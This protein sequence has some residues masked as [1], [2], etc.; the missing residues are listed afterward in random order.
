MSRNIKFLYLIKLI[1]IPLLFKNNKQPMIKAIF[2]FMAQLT[3]FIVICVPLALIL[4][5][6]ANIFFELKRITKWIK[7]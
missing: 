6:T 2:I 7:N 4:L 3:Y 5:L 1:I